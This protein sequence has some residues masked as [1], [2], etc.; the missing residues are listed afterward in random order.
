MANSGELV[1][2]KLTLYELVELALPMTSWWQHYL[3]DREK[4]KP[5]QEYRW[6]TI[7]LGRILFNADS[8]GI[9]LNDRPLWKLFWNWSDTSS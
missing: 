6:L 9:D 7:I 5:T 2:A 3:F 1:V 4:E 8:K